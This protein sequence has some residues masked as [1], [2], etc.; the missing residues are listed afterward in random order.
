MEQT[1]DI[2]RAGRGTHFDPQVVD[3]L[4][5]NL[6]DVTHIWDSAQTGQ[7]TLQKSSQDPDSLHG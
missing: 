6:D 4:L 3:V 5:D 2:I 7:T 1:V